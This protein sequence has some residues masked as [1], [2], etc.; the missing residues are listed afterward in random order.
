LHPGRFS[1]K[2]LGHTKPGIQGSVKT[3]RLKPG[4][5]R[6]KPAYAG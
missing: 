6:I 5:T 4:A 1:G 2:S 3:H